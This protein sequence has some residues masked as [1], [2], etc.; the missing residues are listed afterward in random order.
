MLIEELATVA[1]PS[2][3]SDL[4]RGHATRYPK[5]ACSVLRRGPRPHCR[6]GGTCP[7]AFASPR[8]RLPALPARKTMPTRGACRTLAWPPRPSRSRPL[9]TEKIVNDVSKDF[10]ENRNRV[11]IREMLPLSLGDGKRQHMPHHL[12]M[13]QTNH[14]REQTEMARRS[15]LARP[16]SRP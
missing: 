3:P 16:S 5:R 10:R 1:R 4:D 11:S 13:Y 6:G 9:P 7:A 14:T 12:T 15:T 8:P 2:G